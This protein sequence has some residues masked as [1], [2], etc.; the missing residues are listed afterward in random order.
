MP[1]PSAN[2]AAARWLLA[3]FDAIDPADVLAERYDY[4]ADDYWRPVHVQEMFTL[5]SVM[6]HGATMRV[7][8]GDYADPMRWWL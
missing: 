1:E 7:T 5:K 2:P 4:A 3:E 6:D 8:Q